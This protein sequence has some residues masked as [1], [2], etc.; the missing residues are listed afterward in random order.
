MDGI[1][2]GTDPE[3]FIMDKKTKDFVSAHNYF[4][5]TKDAPF[6]VRDGA[7]Q[8][9]GVAAEFNI[10]PSDNFIDFA[11]RIASVTTVMRTILENQDPDLELV[12]TP[13]ATFS[14]EYF[15]TLPEETK[16]LGC[17]PDYNAWTKRMNEPPKTSEPFR[18]GAGHIHVGWL[19]DTYADVTDEDE[20][21]PLCRKIVKTMDASL[22]VMS[23][24]WDDDRKRR[25]LYGRKGAFRPKL[26]GLEYRVLSNMFLYKPAIVEWV[27]EAAMHSAELVLKEN[28]EIYKSSEALRNMD[29]T[30]LTEKELRYYNSFL[31]GFG[32]EPLS[33]EILK[34]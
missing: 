19:D 30:L 14:R 20:F 4:P 28:V 12:V 24:A 23:Q 22:F 32:Y 8:V 25:S 33:E 2:I 16:K 15:D 1:L 17:S 7:I 3:I 6:S 26:Y 10:T 21:L 11:G 13:T 5:G 34:V 18:T 31:V 29:I 9:D 27:F